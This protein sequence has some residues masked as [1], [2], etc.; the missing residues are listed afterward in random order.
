MAASGGTT[1]SAR[2]SA[3]R[4]SFHACCQN[5]LRYLRRLAVFLISHL[6]RFS[7]KIFN[8]LRFFEIFRVPGLTSEVRLCPFFSVIG[9]RRSFLSSLFLFSVLL[10]FLCEASQRRLTFPPVEVRQPDDAFCF[11]WSLHRGRLHCHTAFNKE[12]LCGAWDAFCW[13]KRGQRDTLSR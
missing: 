9:S 6:C 4:S 12:L 2:S 5:G 8:A 11:F 7:F 3:S 13:W 1:Y 10:L